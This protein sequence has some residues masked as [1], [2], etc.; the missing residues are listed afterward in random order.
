MNG[1]LVPD[2]GIVRFLIGGF[3][4][5]F[6]LNTVLGLGYGNGFALYAGCLAWGAIRRRRA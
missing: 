5:A 2:F 3:F 4:V 6:V 1:F